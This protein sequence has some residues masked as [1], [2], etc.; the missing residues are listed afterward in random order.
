M[1]DG[2]LEARS[3]GVILSRLPDD[4]AGSPVQPLPDIP[5]PGYMLVSTLSGKQAIVTATPSL[6]KS[7]SGGIVTDVRTFGGFTLPTA[8]PIAALPT[9][10][11]PPASSSAASSPAPQHGLSTPKLAAAI[12]VPLVLLAILSPVVIVWYLSYRRKRR[13]LKRPSGHSSESTLI[14]HY[15]GHPR[16]SPRHQNSPPSTE[17]RKKPKRPHRIVSVPTPTFSSFNFE[18]SRPA[19][20]GPTATAPSNPHF[21]NNNHSRR[22]PRN[23]RSATLSWGSPP[24]YASPTRRTLTSPIPRL[25]TP[26]MPHSPFLETAQMVHL[27]PIGVGSSQ[28]SLPYSNHSPNARHPATVSTTTIANTNPFTTSPQNQTSL[29]PPPHALT[30]HSSTDS[31][32]E[33]LHHRSTLTRPFSL[34]PSSSPALSDISGLSFDAT[35]WAS[36]IYGRDSV[37]SPF[38][39]DEGGEGT[40]VRP[41]QVV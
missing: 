8:T 26:D 39:D 30:R 10:A 18:L 7:K 13:N 23:R 16:P 35:G 31:N 19:S 5:A 14:K 24:P 41:H 3:E 25:D 6:Q 9:P 11:P 36:A 28:Q 40:G 21:N 29:H 1:A 2:L 32:P 20:V 27:Q 17:Q 38:F 22:I 33:S 12:V 4:V 15:H 37:V 34:Q